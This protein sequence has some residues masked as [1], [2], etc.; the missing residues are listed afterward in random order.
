[1]RDKCYII[2]GGPEACDNILK[3][4]EGFIICADSGYNKLNGIKKPDI[5]SGDFD[6]IKGDIPADCEIISASP[7][8]DDTDTLMAIPTARDKGYTDITLCGA[9]GGRADHSIANIQ[10][11]IYMKDR[12]INCRIEGDEICCYIIRNEKI[13]IPHMDNAYLSVFSLSDESKV[14]IKNAEYELSEYIMKNSYPIGVS[15][16]FTNDNCIITCHSGTVL[17]MTV[18]KTTPLS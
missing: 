17:I 13:T 7:H 3:R 14:S 5:V 9:M 18:T 15:N 2:C 16:E 4:A 8:K 1:M 6:S 10:A 11:L 12:G